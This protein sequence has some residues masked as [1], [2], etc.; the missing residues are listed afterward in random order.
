MDMVRGIWNGLIY[1]FSVQKKNTLIIT[2]FWWN[3]E[4]RKRNGSPRCPNISRQSQGVQKNFHE[5]SFEKK[6]IYFFKKIIEC[7]Y[8][9]K[10]ENKKFSWMNFLIYL[11]KKNNLRKNT[12]PL[13]FFRSTIRI[14]ESLPAALILKLIPFF[15][16]V[17]F[18]C[19]RYRYNHA[20]F[21][22][23]IDADPLV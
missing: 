9:S 11:S 21:R 22:W 2:F 20:D 19:Q 3:S 4:A 23:D 18:R 14:K 10:I 17:S 12:P 15:R 5:N 8:F 1:L 7:T 6:R 16:V 13:F